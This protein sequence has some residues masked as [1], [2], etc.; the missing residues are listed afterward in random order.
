MMKFSP[1]TYRFSIQHSVFDIRYSLYF[2][3]QGPNPLQIVA[4]RLQLPSGRQQF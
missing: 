4:N 3:I 2:C 1:L